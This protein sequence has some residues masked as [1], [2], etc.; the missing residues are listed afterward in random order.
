MILTK[1]LFGIDSHAD[2]SP[3]KPQQ[4]TSD[5]IIRNRLMVED[6]FGCRAPTWTTPPGTG[7]LIT[8]QRNSRQQDAVTRLSTAKP[9]PTVQ[10]KEFREA[11]CRNKDIQI[12]DRSCQPQ[13]YMRF[14]KMENFH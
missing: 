6:I 8:V 7:S 2:A 10:H 9:S 4:G 1:P 11:R 5:V 3:A 13:N 14:N 12:G